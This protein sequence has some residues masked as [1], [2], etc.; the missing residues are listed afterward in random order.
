MMTTAQRVFVF[1][2]A[3]G[4][5]GTGRAVAQE[6]RR[7]GRPYPASITLFCRNPF[8]TERTEVRTEVTELSTLSALWPLW[9][10]LRA[11]LYVQF[12]GKTE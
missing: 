7:G 9:A 10:G 11:L 8:V 12:N 2:F 1:L 5:G 6:A 4:A 3:A